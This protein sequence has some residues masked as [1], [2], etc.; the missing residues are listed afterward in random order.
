M[1]TDTEISRTRDGY[2]A[3]ADRYTE[4]FGD[5]ADLESGALG[6]AM[7]AAFAERAT[8][9]GAGPVAD[10]GC[11]PGLITQLLHELGVDAFGIDLTPRMVQLASAA[12]PHLA[13]TE[14]T[15]T[16]LDLADGSLG[17]AVAWYSVIHTPPPLLP[18][19]F[20][21][22]HRVLTP[23]A[24]LLLAFQV[25]DE[26]LRLTEAFGEKV[27]LLFRRLTP[28]RVTGLLV[29]AGLTP[30]AHLVREPYENERTRQ[31]YVLARK[32]APKTSSGKSDD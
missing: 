13:F 28:E 21:E 29:G 16:D 25:G 5:R 20:S 17:G 10:I 31:A 3:I 27:D 7:L 18:R 19:V 15:M 12:Y 2:N 4:H 1:T 23:G 22:F 8:K 24:P 32:E 9:P 30:E 6:R 26:P 14:G 11:G